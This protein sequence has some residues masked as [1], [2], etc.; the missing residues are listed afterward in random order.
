MYK[1]IADTREK[2]PW[3]FSI[4]D[5]CDETINLKLDTGDYTIQG[6]EQDL[7]IE[8]K[9]TTGEIALNIGKDT[10]RWTKELE[11]MSKITYAHLILEF[12]IDDVSVFPLRSN[13]PK[14]K[15]KDLRI[16]SKYLLKN[17]FSYKDKYNINVHFCQNE[18]LAFQ[19]CEEI[20]NNVYKEIIQPGN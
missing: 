15:W 12:S 2:F 20:F 18:Y 4:C 3:D 17:L 1:V 5:N 16:N 6:F 19:K 9:R 10:Y 7:A 11:R 14:E 8:R 13:I